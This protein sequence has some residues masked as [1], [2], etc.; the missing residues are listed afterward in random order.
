MCLKVEHT[1]VKILKSTY[2]FIYLKIHVRQKKKKKKV[3]DKGDSNKT[4]LFLY[5]HSQISSWVRIMEW[6]LYNVL[7]NEIKWKRVVIFF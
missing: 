3:I 2:N 7:D 4:K 6:E 1:L 5:Y